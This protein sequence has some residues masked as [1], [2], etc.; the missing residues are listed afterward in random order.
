[1]ARLKIAVALCTYNGGRYIG[2]QLESIFRQERRP[3]IVMAFDDGSS[4]DTVQLLEAIARKAPVPLLL[5][6]NLKNL[7]FVRNF[8]Q[9]IAQCDADVIALCDQDD[10]WE[11]EKLRVMESVFLQDPNAAAVFSDALIVDDQLRPLGSTLLQL[12]ASDADCQAALAGEAFPALL[13]RNVVCGAALAIRSRAA[14]SI[15]PIPA[16]AIHDE[17]IALVIAANGGLRFIARPLIRYRQ[18]GT[19]QIG[20]RQLT[21][22]RRLHTFIHRHGPET[23]RRLRLMRS[24]RERLVDTGAQTS[25]LKAVDE[26]IRHLEHRLSVSERSFGRIAAISC[27]IRSGR[28]KTFSAGWASAVRDLLLPL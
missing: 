3:D 21:W 13:R 14:T 18:H 20:L 6:R 9:A 2:L 26:V 15:L 19:S 27:E 25:R 4:D 17:W 28:Y 23:K 11:P 10:Y 24:L 7:G 8:E 1:M 12:R 5:K 22:H 16:D